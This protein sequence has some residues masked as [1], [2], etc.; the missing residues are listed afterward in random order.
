MSLFYGYEEK[1]ALPITEG[2]LTGGLKLGGNINMSLNQV[3]NVAAANDPGYVITK[4]VL[5]QRYLVEY[6][7]LHSW[8][9]THEMDFSDRTNAIYYVSGSNKVTNIITKNA[10]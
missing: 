10:V 2:E 3:K 5:E 8:Q 7:K 6:K 1:T 4:R 9:L